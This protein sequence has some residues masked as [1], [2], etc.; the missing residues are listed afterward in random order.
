MVTAWCMYPGASCGHRAPAL[1]TSLLPSEVGTEQMCM[2]QG[3]CMTQMCMEQIG[4]KQ[5][6]MEQMCTEQMCKE[7][8]TCAKQMW[9]KW[10]CPQ[11]GMCMV[12]ICTKQMCMEQGMCVD[13]L[14]LEQGMCMDQGEGVEELPQHHEP[15]F[16]KPARADTGLWRAPCPR[17]SQDHDCLL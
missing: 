16:Q 12:Q 1:A 15:C 2:E 17:T 14:G 9:T 11:Q 4:T 13:W 10:M 3:M 5:M 6:C 7:Q 8:G